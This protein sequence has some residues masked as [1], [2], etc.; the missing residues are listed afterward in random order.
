MS[1]FVLPSIKQIEN[2]ISERSRAET[3]QTV[4]TITT[5]RKRKRITQVNRN[6]TGYAR[7]LTSFR[8]NRVKKSVRVTL[9]A[10]KVGKKRTPEAIVRSDKN[11]FTI[12]FQSILEADLLGELT[13]VDSQLG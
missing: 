7:I 1:K 4:E 8:V 3:R 2:S 12:G 6:K 13:T 5:S 11:S 10:G 9:I